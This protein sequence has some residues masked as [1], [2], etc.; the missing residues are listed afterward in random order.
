MVTTPTSPRGRRTRTALLRAA[1]EVFEEK[2]F[3][4]ARIA[5]ITARAGA[6]Y[7]SFYTYF[8]SKEAVFRELVQDF[9][10]AVFTASRASDLPGASP[11]D[12]IRHT[13]RVYLETVADHAHLIVVFEQVAA[14]DEYF[15]SL[16]LE[17][18]DMFIDRIAGG[19]RRL[20]ADGLA[21][22]DL[23]A[24]MCAHLLGGMIENI[25]RMMY[26]YR[27]PLNLERL[28]DEATAL[29]ARAIGLRPGGGRTGRDIS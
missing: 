3:D 4:E 7:G 1:R 26:T 18:R 15:R 17:V 21:A 2:G 12:K 24:V 13:T 11:E 8:G 28:V 27:Q 9:A 16:L 29:W 25:G 14:R 19:T 23:D 10:R 6:A 5:D 20:Q 22:P